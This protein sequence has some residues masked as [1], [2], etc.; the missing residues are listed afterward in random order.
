MFGRLKLT[1]QSPLPSKVGNLAML[2]AMRLASS[3][4]SDLAIRASP[5]S[6]VISGR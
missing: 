5:E 1:R 6:D 3:R 2:L 4:V